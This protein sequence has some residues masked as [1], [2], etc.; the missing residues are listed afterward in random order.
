MIRTV[1]LCVNRAREAF[2][3]L[4]LELLGKHYEYRFVDKVSFLKALIHFNDEICDSPHSTPLLQKQK[5]KKQQ[6]KTTT[7]IMMSIY[8]Y[9]DCLYFMIF[10]S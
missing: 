4:L 2:R 7:T 8:Y 1:R 10:S 9:C 6:Q 5:Q 3:A